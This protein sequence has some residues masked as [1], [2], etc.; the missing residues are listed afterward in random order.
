VRARAHPKAP[1][2]G[3]G[4]ATATG[5]G[6]VSIGVELAAVVLAA[7]ACWGT[8]PPSAGEW[9]RWLLLAALAVGYTEAT[10]R[11][12]LLYRYLSADHG[13]IS[14]MVAVWALPAALILPPG[15]A[16]LVNLAV[17]VH[18]VAWTART[19]ATRMHRELFT[20]ATGA[21]ATL[22]ASVISDVSGAR[23]AFWSSSWSPAAALGAL[24][25][26]LADT[27]VNASLVVAGM[28]AAT[29]PVALRTLLLSRDDFALECATLILGVFLAVTLTRT[30]GLTPAV[31]AVLVL[32]QRSALV[33]KLR[34]AATHDGKTGLTSR[35]GAVASTIP[36]PPGVTGIAPSTLAMPYA[37]KSSNG[38]T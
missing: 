10:S 12:E 38:S 29:R 11:V 31:T 20:R 25:A 17:T 13:P 16:V 6:A 24:V 28:Y 14:S 2:S 37:A 8:R 15:L 30:P 19:A 35:A 33:A 21:L 1:W 26:V 5:C 32:L 4:L 9:G 34:A 36:K 7:A 22:A 23:A 27:L 18:L 3:A